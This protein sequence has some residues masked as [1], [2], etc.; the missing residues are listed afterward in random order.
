MLSCQT[1]SLVAF[2]FPLFPFPGGLLSRDISF[3]FGL[4]ASSAFFL[5]SQLS[6]NR[7]RS[8]VGCFRLFFL[9]GSSRIE[10]TFVN[11]EIKKIVC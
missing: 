10:T 1:F 5:L 9:I 4:P 3:G 2:P 11:L 6:R 8:P 7:F